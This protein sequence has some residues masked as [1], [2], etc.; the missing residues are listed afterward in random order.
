[1]SKF[2]E[3]IGDK[4]LKKACKE[5]VRSIEEADQYETRRDLHRAVLRL[6]MQ[7]GHWLSKEGPLESDS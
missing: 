1:M 3:R 2:N 7:L 6:R 4:T 5:L